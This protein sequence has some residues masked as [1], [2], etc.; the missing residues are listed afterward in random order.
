MIDD[1]DA[2]AVGMAVK[3]LGL[4]ANCVIAGIIRDGELMIPRGI[5]TL[6]AGDEVLAITDTEGARMIAKLLETL[7]I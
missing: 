2:Q 4:P 6:A 3:D 1:A 7:N 5:T